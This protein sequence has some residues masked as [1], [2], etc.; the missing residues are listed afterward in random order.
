[1]KQTM[2]MKDNKHHMPTWS[3]FRLFCK[4]KQHNAVIPLNIINPNW[5]M[6]SVIK[7]SI[8]KTF[9]TAVESNGRNPSNS[10]E[11]DVCEISN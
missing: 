8:K 2:S 9:E 10:D 4:T 6:M 11:M 7:F 3:T 1:M 5:N